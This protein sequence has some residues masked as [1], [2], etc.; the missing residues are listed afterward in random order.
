VVIQ[1]Q[2]AREAF[3]GG[4]TIKDMVKQDMGVIVLAPWVFRREL[5][6]NFLAAV[7]LGKKKLN[8]NWCALRSLDHKPSLEEET[9]GRLCVSA[10]RSLNLAA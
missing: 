9:F 10:A 4:E 1:A 8:R 6:E 3:L 7:P 5:E 2:A